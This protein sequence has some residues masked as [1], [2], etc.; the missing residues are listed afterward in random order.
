MFLATAGLRLDF[1]NSLV[2]II[3]MPIMLGTEL[4]SLKSLAKKDPS[5]IGALSQVF[6]TTP[7]SGVQV[8]SAT[9]NSL[10]HAIKN[11]LG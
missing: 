9:P 4:A 2:N 11:I 10:V 8:P 1:A 5:A 3:S 6:S 7:G